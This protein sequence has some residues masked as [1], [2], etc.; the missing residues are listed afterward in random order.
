MFSMMAQYHTSGLTQREFCNEA[1][2]PKS[3]FQ[4]W[5]RRY[6]QAQEDTVPAAQDGGFVELRS[7]EMGR[8]GHEMGLELELAG[9]HVLRFSGGLPPV[10]YLQNLIQQPAPC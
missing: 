6:R 4:Y 9:G 8:S 1:A 7:S 3:V 5:W 10:A 2:L